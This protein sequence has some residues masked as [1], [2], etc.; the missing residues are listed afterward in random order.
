ME[1]FDRLNQHAHH[2]VALYRTAAEAAGAV[3]DLTKAELADAQV[4]ILMQHSDEALAAGARSEAVRDVSEGTAA[5]TIVGLVAGTL[6]FALPGAGTV[7]GAGLWTATAI[8][9][10]VGATIGLEISDYHHAWEGLYRRGVAEGGTLVA[11]STDDQQTAATAMGILRA[12]HPT[13]I[14][15]FDRHGSRRSSMAHT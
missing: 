2:V 8:G 5:G 6:A 14:D 4:S 10:A 11:V 3:E 13:T 1:P 15:H 12:H 9:A 7:I